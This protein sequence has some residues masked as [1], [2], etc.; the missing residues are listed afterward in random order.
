MKKNRARIKHIFNILIERENIDRLGLADRV[1]VKR[2]FT[3]EVG[4]TGMSLAPF[5][6]S[7]P[8]YRPRRKFNG[9]CAP[10]K[11]GAARSRQ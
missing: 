8:V 10:L 3:S 11:R 6:L 2:G 7:M 4:A 9:L 5:Y 1:A